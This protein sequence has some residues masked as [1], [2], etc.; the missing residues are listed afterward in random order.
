[1][2]RKSLILAALALT[3]APL[4]AQQVSAPQVGGDI[5][6]NFAY[7]TQANDYIKRDVMI[8]MRDGVKLHTVI[9]IPK[10]ATN[11]PILLTRTPYNASARAQR[12]ASPNMVSVLPQGDEPFRPRRLYP[13]VPGY[14]RQ[15]WVGGGL[16]RYPPGDRP[17]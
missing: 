3:A 17:A 10:G 4:A 8:P 2:H 15:I 16:C 11:A 9:V 7:P 1:M 14:P 5:P 6:A 12:M 13:R